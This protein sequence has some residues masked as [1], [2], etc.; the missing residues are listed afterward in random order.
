MNMLHPCIRHV[1]WASFCAHR[2][3]PPPLSAPPSNTSALQTLL[4]TPFF[5]AASEAQGDWLSQHHT[6]PGGVEI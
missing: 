2:S 5:E 3:Y 1:L 4:I 6:V